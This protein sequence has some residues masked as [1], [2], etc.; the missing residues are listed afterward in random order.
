MQE[1]Y[2]GRCE[3]CGKYVLETELSSVWTAQM[4]E[5][6]CSECKENYANGTWT[7][8]AQGTTNGSR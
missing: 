3:K 8:V 2:L 1:D 7:T 6:W 4:E 5:L